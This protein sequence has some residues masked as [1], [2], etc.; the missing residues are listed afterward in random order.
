MCLRSR[1]KPHTG[2]AINAA[3]SE[4]SK[5]PIVP[6]AG[7][8]RNTSVSPSRK[9]GTKP[10]TVENTAIKMAQLCRLQL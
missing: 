3:K 9:Q 8:N 5:P 2:N 4:K 10:I 1:R 7:E 6:T